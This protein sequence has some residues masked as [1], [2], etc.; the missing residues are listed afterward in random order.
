LTVTGGIPSSLPFQQSETVYE[1]QLQAAVGKLVAGITQALNTVGTAYTWTVVPQSSAPFSD[2]GEVYLFE[3]NYNQQGI[4]GTRDTNYYVYN[5]V[6]TPVFGAAAANA[7]VTLVVGL[8][9]DGLGWTQTIPGFPQ[10]VDKPHPHTIFWNQVWN[11]V[12]GTGVVG[13]FNSKDTTLQNYLTLTNLGLT[14]AAD[15]L[16]VIYVRTFGGTAATVT[17]IAQALG[18]FGITLQRN[19]GTTAQNV[20]GLSVIHRTYVNPDTGVA[21]WVG[22]VIAPVQIHIRGTPKPPPAP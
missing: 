1:P 22:S 8:R 11:A 16:N 12:G 17:P 3:K 20:Q 4:L 13:S 21:P 14:A 19:T 9:H 15:P 6:L 10:H 5:P 18:N 7:Q 2:V